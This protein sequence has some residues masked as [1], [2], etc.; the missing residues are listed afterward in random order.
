MILFVYTTAQG[1]EYDID[2]FLRKDVKVP[3][4]M[5]VGSFH[6]A[7]PGMD[8]HKTIE[9]YK[10]D[11]L[12]D[13]KQ[14]ELK[15]LLD[16]IS[17]FNPTKIIV[18]S[19]SNT[20][21]LMDRYRNWKAGKEDLKRNEIDQIGIKLMDRFG[22]DTL[23]GVD[24]KG[25]SYDMATSSDS[26][27]YKNLFSEIYGDY[28]LGENQ[29]E[30]NYWD[31]YAHE[32]ILTYEMSLLDYFQHQNSDIVIERMHGH[33]ILS[34]KTKDYNQIDGL[35]LNW[36]NRNL[37][38]YKEIT[39]IETVPEDRIMILFGAGHLAILKQQFRC[40]PEFDLINFKDLKKF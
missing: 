36:Y 38:T 16:Y 3:K 17:R 14:A 21:Y 10:V 27:N 2:S 33:Y 15:D 23:Y 1:Q 28:D 39:M 6:F 40:S 35:T 32:D 7:Y 19:R 29:I 4:V 9:K 37:R 22:L 24:T 26:S 20:A 13:Q 34:D 5:L 30:M 8:S 31:W 11:I 18:E 12:S 25:M